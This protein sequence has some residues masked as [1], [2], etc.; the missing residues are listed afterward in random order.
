MKGIKQIKDY[1][2]LKE[3]GR[4]ANG[5]VYEA[6]EDKSNKFVAIKAIP[7]D[8]LN[9]PRL[10]E[11]FKKELKTLY[12]LSHKNIIKII[13]VEKTINNVYLIL[14]YCNGGTLYDYS[15]FYKRTYKTRIPEFIVQKIIKQ[16]IEGLKFMHK[17][18]IIHRDIKLENILINFDDQPNIYSEN[19]LINKSPKDL[20]NIYSLEKGNFTIKIADLGYARDLE[21]GLGAS[22]ICGTPMTIAP[23]I[24]NMYSNDGRDSKYNSAIDLWS[25]GAVLYELLMGVS[26]FVGESKEDIMR[27]VYSG[28]YEISSNISVSIESIYLLNGLLQ[29]YPHKRLNWDQIVFHPFINKD[30]KK[31]KYIKLNSIINENNDDDINNDNKLQINSKDCS[32]FLWILFQATGASLPF[33]LDQLDKDSYQ[34]VIK[35]VIANYMFSNPEENN[36]LYEN[37]HHIEA[38][39]SNNNNVNN[40]KNYNL[41][42]E[43]DNENKRFQDINAEDNKNKNN[44]PNFE[45]VNKINN[46]H[47]PILN[48]ESNFHI[49]QDNNNFSPKKEK[50]EEMILKNNNKEE[51]IINGKISD[52]QNLIADSNIIKKN[53]DLSDNKNKIIEEEKNHNHKNKK[54]NIKEEKKEKIIQLSKENN[55]DNK[56]E[57]SA[58]HQKLSDEANNTYIKMKEEVDGSRLT[59][60]DE[61]LKKYLLLDKTIK[62]NDLYSN[63]EAKKNYINGSIDSQFSKESLNKEEDE[64]QSKTYLFI[65]V[66]VN[67]YEKIKFFR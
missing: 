28:M 44:L 66:L 48:N 29:F 47:E 24:V 1:R 5:I 20:Y 16:V 62:I 53:A 40:N 51:K 46:H 64:R 52:F 41:I 59:D 18:H 49:L 13:G 32:N 36:S 23:E 11:Q 12:R 54:I 33:E 8:K 7:N 35:D 60:N 39:Y 9:N 55:H 4:G 19:T 38:A 67:I 57:E 22:T 61:V 63:P 43:L 15:Q 2:L 27:K 56:N 21:G 3:L 31:F 45:N 65:L 58:N 17:S 10:M 37:N 14:E 26:P 6:V 42:I 34:E 30:V 25:L 50:E